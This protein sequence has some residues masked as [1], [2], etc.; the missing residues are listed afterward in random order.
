[1]LV[2]NFKQDAGISAV[3]IPNLCAKH[4]SRASLELKIS[5]KL[6]YALI[7]TVIAFK[8]FNRT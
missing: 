5:H 1:M 2:A 7:Q 4:V 8:Y 6:A 3:F